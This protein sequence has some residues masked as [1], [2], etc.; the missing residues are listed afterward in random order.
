MP[1]TLDPIMVPSFVVAAAAI[2]LIA[3]CA[4]EGLVKPGMVNL[5]ATFAG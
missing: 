4:F 3:A 1:N 2:V 5:I